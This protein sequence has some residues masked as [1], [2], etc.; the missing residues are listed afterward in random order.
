MDDGETEYSLEK[1]PTIAYE[2]Y[3]SLKI[4]VESKKFLIDELKEFSHGL[5]ILLKKINSLGGQK[6]PYFKDKLMVELPFSHQTKSTKM[7]DVHISGK[8]FNYGSIQFDA[9]KKV[10]NFEIKQLQ[11]NEDK[12][13]KLK[14]GKLSFI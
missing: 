3:D 7:M 13:K 2:I 6:I 9:L 4:I 12:P 10:E 1:L 11:N 14:I 5:S 8:F